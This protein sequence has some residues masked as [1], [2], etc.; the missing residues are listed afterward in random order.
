MRL[1]IFISYFLLSLLM[2]NSFVQAAENGTLRV[3][4]EAGRFQIF[5]KVKAVRC[6]LKSRGECDAPVFFDLNTNQSLP[7][8]SYVVGFENSLYPDYV[9]VKANQRV[10]L[11]LEKVTVPSG[12]KGERVR[13]YRDFSRLI[14]HKKIYLA[15]YAMGRHFFRLDSSNFGDF[16]LAGSWE[17]DSVQRFTYDFCSKLHLYGEVPEA[18]KQ[19]CSAWNS[20]TKPMDLRQLFSFGNDGTFTEMWVTYPGDV[21]PSSHNRYLVSTPMT[22]ADFVAVF[23]GAYRISEEGKKAKSVSVVTSGIPQDD[24]I[25]VFSGEGSNSLFTLT[26]KECLDARVWNTEFRAHCS[27][28]KQEGCDRSSV[29]SC[30]AMQ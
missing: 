12:L 28:D 25:N 5:Q 21:I 20:A 29:K 3:V 24:S 19:T 22:T 17:R 14:E 26:S 8:G 11:F 15:M 2:G 13:V 1:V 16:Y 6:N 10:D 30:Q 23:P 9:S 4:G 27:S 18:A 7:A